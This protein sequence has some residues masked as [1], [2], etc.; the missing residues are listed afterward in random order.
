VNDVAVHPL[1]QI[2][3]IPSPGYRGRQY[4]GHHED[5]GLRG[6][7]EADRIASHETFP[8]ALRQRLAFLLQKITDE[9]YMATFMIPQLLNFYF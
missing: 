7:A 6:G 8:N 5:W 9:C 3:Y 4:V 1:D 2:G